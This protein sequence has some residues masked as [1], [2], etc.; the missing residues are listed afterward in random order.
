MARIGVK[1]I[2]LT[3]LV[4]PALYAQ[5]PLSI[6]VCHPTVIAFFKPASNAQEENE[7]G[8]NESLSDFRF[9]SDAFQ[10]RLKDKGIDAK[11]VYAAEF[12]TECGKH[13]S[14]FIAKETMVGYY[15][16]APGKS[17]RVEYG[18]MTD[19]DLLK[20]ADEYFGR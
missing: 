18:V 15:F 3:M 4:A 9:Y 1:L 14:T 16:I 7:A 13:V 17:Q 6:N 5:K 2:C 11:V 12:R 19:L 8:Y 20:V 10:Q